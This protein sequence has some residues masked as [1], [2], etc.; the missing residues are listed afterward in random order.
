MY[1]KYLFLVFL[2]VFFL[3]MAFMV[4]ADFQSSSFGGSV[5]VVE[6]PAAPSANVSFVSSSFG[7][8]VEVVEAPAAPSANV[9]FVSSSFGGS[10]DVSGYEWTNYSDYWRIGTF[11]TPSI[12][13]PSPSNNSNNN[14]SGFVW[15]VLINNSDGV[16]FNWSIECDNGQTNSSTDDINGTKNLTLSSLELGGFYTVWVNASSNNSDSLANYTVFYF[17]VTNGIDVASPSPSN[18]SVDV[19]RDISNLSVLINNTAGVVFNWSIETSP[20]IGSNS[21]NGDSNGTKS[22]N[23]SGNLSYGITYIW[24]VNVTD[25]NVTTNLSYLF[26]VEDLIPVSSFNA[27]NFNSSCI[28]LSWVRTSNVSSV[29]IRFKK[30]SYPSSR[31]DGVFLINESVNDTYNHTGLDFGT[32]YYYRIWS[33]NSSDIV[34]SS[35]YVSNNSYTNPGSPSSLQETGSNTSQVSLE[36]TIGNNASRSVVFY[37]ASGVAQY[38]D[39]D[40][41]VV[42]INATGN[43]GV[44]SGLDA[45]ITYWF[46]VYSYN[47]VSGLWSEG[48][49]TVNASTNTSAGSV[50]SLMVERYDDTQLNLSW[51]KSN[52]LDDVVVVRKTGSYPV[53][54]SD[55][56]VVYNGSLFSYKDTGL[57]PATKYFYRAWAWNGENF[58]SGYASDSNITRPQPPQEFTGDI[59]SGSLIMTWSKGTGASRTL[60][61]NSTG[62]YPANTSDGTEVYN[63]TGTTTTVSGISSIDYYRGW[64]YVVVDGEGIYSIPA[65]LIWGGIEINVYTESD[66]SVE[67]GNYTVFITNSDASETYENTSVNNPFRID[68]SDVPNGEDIIIQI[69]KEGYKTRSQTM[70]LFENTYYTVDFYLPASSE[71]SPSGE[72]GEP[73]FVNGSDPDNETLASHYIITVEDEVGDPVGS[74]LVT[75]KKYINTSDSYETVVSDY[76]DSSGQIE[77]DLIH[78]TPYYTDITKDNYVDTTA[79]WTPSEIVYVEDAYKTFILVAESTDFDEPSNASYSIDFYGNTSDTV[80]YTHLTLPTN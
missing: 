58:G 26:T 42:G 40:N 65:D 69:Q 41:G 31:S 60:I 48:N 15:S 68:V 78:D 18:N 6:A 51:T 17:N 66:P 20:D 75:I 77:V 56:T 3:S 64:S 25:G 72:S 70:D 22:C 13:S 32:R 73:W 43:S 28:N 74:A 2:F 67:I 71:G 79:Y 44:V 29:Y 62:V 30:D 4:S 35:S 59:D 45:N 7:G 50:S 38:P 5:E 47:P 9:S 61:R 49:S 27:S 63:D 76:T 1:K 54:A 53:N 80:S 19:S 57:T 39:R 46:S 23:V 16:G 55:G 24:Y 21:S 8:S 33:Y 11:K 34:F 52:S 36:W 14:P 10:V 37:N 12:T